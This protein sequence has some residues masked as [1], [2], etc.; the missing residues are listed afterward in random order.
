MPYVTGAIPCGV[1]SSCPSGITSGIVTGVNET[2]AR[3]VRENRLRRAAG[4]Q[5]LTLTRSR[6]RDPLAV[7]YGRVQV[8]RSGEVVF[9]TTDL[10]DL[11]RWLTQPDTR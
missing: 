2:A 4:R 7:D 1:V 5:G 8:L 3:K 11:E 9:S 6:K 10:D